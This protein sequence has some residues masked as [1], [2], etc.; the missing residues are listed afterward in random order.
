MYTINFA[1]TIVSKTEAFNNS[2]IFSSIYQYKVKLNNYVGLY[3][4]VPLNNYYLCKIK[5]Y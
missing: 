1:L 2:I 4:T 5:F 3:A